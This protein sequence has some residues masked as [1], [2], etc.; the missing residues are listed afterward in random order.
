MAAPRERHIKLWTLE[1]EDAD[2]EYFGKVK[3]GDGQS[4]ASLRER[5]EAA[6]V[7]DWPFEFWD[8]EDNCRIR[9]NFKALNDIL[10]EVHVIPVGCGNPLPAKRRRLEAET[11]ADL[12]PV[13]ESGLEFGLWSPRCRS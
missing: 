12:E 3:V 2:P 1:D 4:Y 9:W 5:L 8:V 6:N 10:E 7:L 11:R 13:V